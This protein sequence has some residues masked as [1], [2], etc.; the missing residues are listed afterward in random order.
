MT[1]KTLLTTAALALAPAFAAAQGCNSYDHGSDQA[2]SCVDGTQWDA[3]SGTCV[4]VST[5][6]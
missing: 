5:T 6:S 1:L 2:M 3:A 4:A